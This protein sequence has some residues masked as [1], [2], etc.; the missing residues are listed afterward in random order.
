MRVCAEVPEWRNWQTQ[1][2][3]NLPAL[4][5]RV[6]STPSSGIISNQTI[7]IRRKTFIIASRKAVP[8]LLRTK[9]FNYFPISYQYYLSRKKN[10]FKRN[11]FVPFLFYPCDYIRQYIGGN[12]FLMKKQYG[13][14]M[15]RSKIILYHFSLR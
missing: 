14:G 4:R 11:N 8:Q 6:G 15:Y 13:A 2:T 1:Q 12:L 7:L 9:I 3:Q 5:S 10:F